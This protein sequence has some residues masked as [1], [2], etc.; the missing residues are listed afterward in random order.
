MLEWQ[1]YRS[2]EKVVGANGNPIHTSNHAVPRQVIQLCQDSSEKNKKGYHKL[3][4]ENAMQ[5]SP[6]SCI[7][8]PLSQPS[9]HLPS[10]P[11]S[12]HQP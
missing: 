6:N 5:M 11:P 2:D 12:L 8:A 7:K 4:P 9:P 10:S 3:K 1:D